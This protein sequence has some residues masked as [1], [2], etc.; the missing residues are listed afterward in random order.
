MKTYCVFL[1]GVNVNGKTMKMAEACE[2]L[3]T[4]GFTGVT[5]VLASGNLIFQSDP[6]Y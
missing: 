3:K 6:C 1:R 5:S 2:V 4:A